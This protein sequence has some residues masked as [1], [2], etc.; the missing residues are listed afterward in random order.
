[1][2]ERLRKLWVPCM[3][4]HSRHSCTDV[5]CDA[6]DVEPVRTLCASS[7]F[8][9]SHPSSTRSAS[10]WPSPLVRSA[11]SNLPFSQLP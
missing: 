11:A 4:E 7:E 3:R 6:H 10:T 9:R 1:M 2:R 8:N 5:D